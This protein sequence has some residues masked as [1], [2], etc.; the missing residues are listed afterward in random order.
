MTRAVPG[1][2][3]R[4]PAIVS[5]RPGNRAPGA[6]DN[7]LQRSNSIAAVRLD[8]ASDASARGSDLQSLRDDLDALA[9]SVPAG[10]QA[11]LDS[12]QAALDAH[13]ATLDDHEARI[14]AIEP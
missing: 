13:Q 14:T 8:L 1:N 7:A 6:I 3:R 4:T 2:R 11:T 5:G 9:A 10:L 12:H